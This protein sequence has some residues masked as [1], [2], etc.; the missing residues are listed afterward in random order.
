MMPSRIMGKPFMVT[1]FNYCFPNNFRA[2]GGVLMGAYASFTGLGRPLP[3]RLFTQH[4]G[5][6]IQEPDPGI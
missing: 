3:L 5:N 4:S 2:E 6:Y 1:E